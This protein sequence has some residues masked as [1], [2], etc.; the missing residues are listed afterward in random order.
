MSFA[1][2]WIKLEIIMVNEI[3]QTEK[4]KCCLFYILCDL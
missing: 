2:K 4:D 3:R 1:R